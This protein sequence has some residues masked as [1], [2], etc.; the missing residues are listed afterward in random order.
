[1]A[2]IFTWQPGSPAALYERIVLAV[3]SIKSISAFISLILLAGI[4]YSIVRIRQIEHEEEEREE[5]IAAPVAE[6]SNKRW[7]RVI[8]H[9]SSESES[10]WR[11][12]ILE[13]DIIL[14]EMLVSMGYHGQ[15]VSD[16]LKGVEKSDFTSIDKAWE[17]HK[18]RNTIAHE[19]ANFQLSAREAKRVINLYRE[20][21]QEF[22][23]I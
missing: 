20:I 13:A 5:A 9:I 14:S 4:I 22:H 6:I 12:A 21:F 17:A 23:F 11:L 2:R 15:S 10:D 8:E 18:V 7:H 19:G 3:Q 1:V 16:M